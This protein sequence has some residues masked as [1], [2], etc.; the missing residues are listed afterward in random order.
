MNPEE[1]DQLHLSKSLHRQE[2]LIHTCQLFLKEKLVSLSINTQH[3]VSTKGNKGYESRYTSCRHN[4]RTYV[5]N[6]TTQPITLPL[7][8]KVTFSY[9]DKI[10]EV[11]RIRLLDKFLVF[12]FSFKD[13]RHNDMFKS[14]HVLKL[15]D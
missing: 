8:V 13:L 14:K 6:R 10:Y 5:A 15:Q 1:A 2:T 12:F 11:P 9:A 7:H 3:S 4:T